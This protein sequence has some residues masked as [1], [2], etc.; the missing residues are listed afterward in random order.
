LESGVCT[1]W[2]LG[3][4]WH[5]EAGARNQLLGAVALPPKQARAYGASRLSLL[6]DEQA[7][8]EGI[9][10]LRFCVPALAAPAVR[11][12]PVRWIARQGPREERG[13]TAPARTVA[14]LAPGLAFA[15]RG[16]LVVAVDQQWLT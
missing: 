14:W 12:F 3:L 13:T 5:A 6:V 15:S 11:G 9:T 10:P 2:L 7:P 16:E 8:R 4:R 1:V